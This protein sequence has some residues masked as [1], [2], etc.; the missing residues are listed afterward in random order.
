MSLSFVVCGI[1]LFYLF[2]REIHNNFNF[3]RWM[4]DH[5]MAVSLVLLVSVLNTQNAQLLSSEIFGLPM[6][7][8]PLSEELEVKLKFYSLISIIIHDGLLL[9][10]EIYTTAF[11]QAFFTTASLGFIFKILSLIVAITLR[12]IAQVKYRQ[13][14]SLQLRKIRSSTAVEEESELPNT[15]PP[16]EEAGS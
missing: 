2:R 7:S 9:F 14:K 11:L 13:N 8:G 10:C 5:L 16:L 4:Q 15:P 12:S 3:R 6:F 1:I